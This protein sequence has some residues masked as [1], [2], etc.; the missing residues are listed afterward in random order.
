MYVYTFFKKIKAHIEVLVDDLIAFAN[1]TSFS[2][3]YLCVH[4]INNRLSWGKQVY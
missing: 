1:Y 4:F 3:M 2:L